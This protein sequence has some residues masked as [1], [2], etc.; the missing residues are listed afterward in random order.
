MVWIL[1]N[2]LVELWR[3]MVSPCN[4]Q[5]VVAASWMTLMPVITCHYTHAPRFWIVWVVHVNGRAPAHWC[6]L[7]CFTSLQFLSVKRT[8]HMSKH[9]L[10]RKTEGS[11]WSSECHWMSIHNWGNNPF[12]WVKMHGEHQSVIPSAPCNGCRCHLPQAQA[13]KVHQTPPDFPANHCEAIADEIPWRMMVTLQGCQWFRKFLLMLFFL[14]QNPGQNVAFDPLLPSSSSH[15]CC[16][17]YYP[18]MFQQCKW[19]AELVS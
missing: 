12:L 8:L 7:R 15:V 4:I 9:R 3:K 13:F 17:E 14:P 2:R 10:S 6:Q 18:F 19:M 11:A 16:Q 1:W 5:A